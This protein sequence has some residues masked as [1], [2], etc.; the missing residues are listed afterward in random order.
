[1]RRTEK[2][3][4]SGRSAPEGRSSAAQRQ[5]VRQARGQARI[6]DAP[7]GG[8]H[9]VRH[10]LQMDDGTV[11]VVHGKGSARI[12]V[13]RLAHRSRIHQICDPQAERQS[14]AVVPFG[15][16]SLEEITMPMKHDRQVRVSEQA[17]RP[18]QGIERA[19]GVVAVEDVIVL[20]ERCAVADFRRVVDVDRT[21]REIQE[22]LTVGVGER[23][24]RPVGREP[25][26]LSASTRSTTAFGSAP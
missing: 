20:I 1:M 21:R 11:R 3:A 10:S 9:V 8:F 6:E 17:Q 26:D 19:L 18:L 22:V 25:G 7:L 23:L 15:D 12:A 24:P 4:R 16:V 5:T 14:C 13:A 2:G